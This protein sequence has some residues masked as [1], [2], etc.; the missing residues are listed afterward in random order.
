M[1]LD[2]IHR[3]SVRALRKELNQIGFNLQGPTGMIDLEQVLYPHY[4]GHPVGIGKS[5]RARTA[6]IS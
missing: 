3:E 2:R 6:G 4:V 5:D 1:S